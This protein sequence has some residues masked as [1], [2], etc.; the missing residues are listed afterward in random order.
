MHQHLCA[1][2]LTFGPLA[3]ISARFSD[4]QRVDEENNLE[5]LLHHMPSGIL[6]LSIMNVLR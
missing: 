3:P 1:V 4:W 2:A 5:L 6:D